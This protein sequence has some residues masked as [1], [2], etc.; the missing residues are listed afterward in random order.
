M[1]PFKWRLFVSSVGGE[2]A[3]TIISVI[4]AAMILAGIPS[5]EAIMGAV[6]VN[7]LSSQA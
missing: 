4:R 5:V 3:G 7:T 1:S 2:V 6:E